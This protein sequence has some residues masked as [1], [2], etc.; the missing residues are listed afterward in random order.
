MGG[1]SL[2]TA[3][4]RDR[5][6]GR[7]CRRAVGAWWDGV[8]AAVLAVVAAVPLEEEKMGWIFLGPG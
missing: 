4:A 8:G 7:V 3:A 6:R 2:R 1:F 5:G